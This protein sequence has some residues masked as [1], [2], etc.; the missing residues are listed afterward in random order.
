MTRKLLPL[1]VAGLVGANVL[2]G[3]ELPNTRPLPTAPPASNTGSYGGSSV[4]SSATPEPVGSLPSPSDF[5]I[6]VLVT[7]S[8]CFGS[9][10]CNVEYEISPAYIGAGS[11]TMQPFRVFYN[12]VGGDSPKT[13]SFT[14]TNGSNMHFDK[15]GSLSTTGEGEPTLSAV[16]TQVVAETG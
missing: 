14:I 4:E 10:G 15:S 3:C 5:R 2:T 6:T 9:A 1:A 8:D 16:V 11:V 13:D 12:I 7:K